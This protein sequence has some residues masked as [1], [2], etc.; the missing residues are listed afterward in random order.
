VASPPL[1]KNESSIFELIQLKKHF[2]KNMAVN[3]ID[4]TISEGE[5]RGLIGPNG[6][7]KTTVFNLVS[8]F[9]QPSGGRVKWQGEEIGNKPPHE[10]V[11]RGISRT[12]QLNVLLKEMT[13]LQNVIMGCRLHSDPGILRQLLRIL[14]TFKDDFNVMEKAL[15]LLEFMG[16]AEM[17]DELA[18]ELPH[19]HQR[20]LGIAIAL[21][22]EPKL[23]LLDEPIT[24]MNPVEAM[25]TMKKIR[26]LRDKGIT[27]LLVEHN[28]RE[29]MNI[30]DNITVINFGEKIAEGTPEEIC[31]NEA[32][33]EAY[34]GKGLNGTEGADVC[35]VLE[36]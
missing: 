11:R 22:T 28:M 6:A 25:E 10:I 5:I 4:L 27:I 17:K 9:L 35:S 12:F 18:G 8:G 32:V 34:L 29:V 30:C 21:A 24:G 20:S 31:S 15:S 1:L 19:G 36:T 14:T 23:L 13:A 16:I 33:V 2:G 26:K 3:G 7:G